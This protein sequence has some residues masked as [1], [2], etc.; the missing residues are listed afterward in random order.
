[1]LLTFNKVRNKKT[2]VYSVSNLIGLNECVEFVS[3]RNILYLIKK[4]SNEMLQN[5][6]NLFR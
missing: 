2:L 3:V 4:I 6:C 5:E 1:M